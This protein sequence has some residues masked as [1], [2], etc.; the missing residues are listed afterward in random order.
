MFL[1]DDI[2]SELDSGR[3]DYIIKRLSGRQ[4]IITGCESEIFD[5]AGKNTVRVENGRITQ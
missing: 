2:L 4:V 5:I 1:L 3:K